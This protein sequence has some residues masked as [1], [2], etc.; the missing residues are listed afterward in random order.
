MNLD[1]LGWNWR[2]QVREGKG[3]AGYGA[4]VPW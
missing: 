2:R 3:S 4:R 1:N